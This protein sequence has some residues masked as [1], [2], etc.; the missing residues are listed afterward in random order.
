MFFHVW[1][2]YPFGTLT[3]WWFWLIWLLVLAYWFCSSHDYPTHFDMYVHFV[4]SVICLGVDYLFVYYLH[5]I[6]ACYSCFYSFWSSYSHLACVWTWMIYL[7]SIWLLVAWLLLSRVIT[8]CLS[9]WVAHLSPHLQPSSF[10][11][12]FFFWFLHLQ[13]WGLVCDCSLWPS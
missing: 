7:H 8:C 6:W 11:H 13:V 5:H 12:S 3:W 2:L 1:S 4:V 10:S 9:M